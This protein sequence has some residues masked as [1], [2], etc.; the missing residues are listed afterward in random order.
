M[1]SI[2]LDIQHKEDYKILIIRCCDGI[3]ANEMN[4]TVIMIQNFFDNCKQN[5]FRF[6]WIWDMKDLNQ[7]PIMAIESLSKLCISNYEI[8]K[9]N[10]ICSCIVSNDGLFNRFFK[11]FTKLYKPVKPLKNFNNPDDCNEFIE[12][13]ILEK[14]NNTDIIY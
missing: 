2:V 6:S 7:L 4:T 1:K 13:C 12:D 10:L 14:Y 8:I 11:F 9:S 3:N 5:N